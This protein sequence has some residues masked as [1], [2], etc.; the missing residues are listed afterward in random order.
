MTNWQIF[1]DMNT[2]WTT[3]VYAQE[4]NILTLSAFSAGSVIVE[5]VTTTPAGFSAKYSIPASGILSIDLSDLV[6]IATTGGFT[7]TECDANGDALSAAVLLSWNTIGKISPLSAI[8]PPF[9][10]EETN[11]VRI[12]PPYMILSGADFVAELLCEFR[13]E[14]Q[15]TIDEIDSEGEPTGG[16]A[17]MPS[18]PIDPGTVFF[19][20]Y[21]TNSP[22]YARTIKPTEC[23]RRYALVEWV[24]YTGA[25]RRH[26]FEIVGVTT[27][28]TEEVNVETLTNEYDIRKNRR[29]GFTLRLE[30]L[31]AYDVWYYSDLITSSDVKIS[32]DGARWYA[33][34]VT[35]KKQTIPNSDEGKLNVLKIPVNYRKYDTL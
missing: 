24:S 3:N 26:V 7:V 29:D 25:T 16:T 8:I 35:A 21:K 9:D 32:V 30:N 34:Q 28:T 1:K 4:R 13:A 5:L 17:Q 11:D 27:E 10:M 22:I 2:A 14:S 31:T 33:V 18:L 6:R 12:C 15:W 23:G 20:L 19:N